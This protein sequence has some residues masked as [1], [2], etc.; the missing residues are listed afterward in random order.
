MKKSVLL[1]LA[2]CS[3]VAT[4][5]LANMDEEYSTYIN[6]D[7]GV[8]WSKIFNKKYVTYAMRASLGER[9]GD[10]FAVETGFAFTPQKKRNYSNVEVFESVAQKSYF[11]SIDLMI[12]GILPFGNFVSALDGLELFAKLGIAFAWTKAQFES[13]NVIP[14]HLEKTYNSVHLAYGAGLAYNFNE[15]FTLNV[16]WQGMFGKRKHQFCTNYDSDYSR[17]R[18]PTTNMVVLGLQYNF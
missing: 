12:K 2:L 9:V 1:T 14:D 8:A 13:P 10:Y 3:A 11:W 5:A 15:N 7:N 4:N 6:L 16:G 17:S 18:T